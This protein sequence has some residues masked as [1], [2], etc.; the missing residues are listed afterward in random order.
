MWWFSPETFPEM[1]AE[2]ESSGADAPGAS[3]RAVVVS[4]KAMLWESSESSPVREESRSSR[5][6]EAVPEGEVVNARVAT[7]VVM[8]SRFA[9]ASTGE[10]PVASVTLIS[11]PGSGFRIIFR[12]NPVAAPGAGSRTADDP[13]AS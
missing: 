11:A 8:Y 1:A 2:P 4:V 3:A 9:A 10:N 12:E 5:P 7:V 13:V 6:W